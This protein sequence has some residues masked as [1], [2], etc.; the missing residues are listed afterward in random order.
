MD[1]FNDMLSK[2][3]LSEE[4][5]NICRDIRRRGKNKVAAQNCRK[6]KLEQ[7]DELQR[8]V[9][10]ARQRRQQLRNEHEKYWSWEAEVKVV[11]LTSLCPGW[12]MST[13]LRRRLSPGS[14]TPSS[15]TTARTPT[16]TQ[17]WWRRTTWKSCQPPQ[18]QSRRDFQ[19]FG[20]Q[21]FL[22]RLKHCIVCCLARGTLSAETSFSRGSVSQQCECDVPTPPTPQ[23]PG[24][25]LGVTRVKHLI[26]KNA[27]NSNYV[28]EWFHTGPTSYDIET[29]RLFTIRSGKHQ[30]IPNSCYMCL[31]YLLIGAGGNVFFIIIL[32]KN[33]VEHWSLRLYR[34]LRPSFW[35]LWLWNL[36]CLYKCFC[37][38]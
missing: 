16:S 6:R 28:L 12:S 21:H 27:I 24:Q 2:E 23:L 8:K 15:P 9:E 14:P 19:R 11:P 35:S 29:Y 33:T 38:K 30:F 18:S 17:S 31:S 25:D 1:E 32:I 20:S 22:L 3:D 36:K 37:N 34:T 10:E 7:I 13:S 5:L 4:Q 26:L